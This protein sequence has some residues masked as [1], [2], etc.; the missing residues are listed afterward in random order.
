MRKLLVLLIVL[1]ISFSL[2]M[3]QYFDDFE[4]DEIG[5]SGQSSKYIIYVLFII[6]S[7]AVYYLFLSQ[8]PKLLSMGKNPLEAAASQC[9]KFSGIVFLLLIVMF[10]SL[11]GFEMSNAYNTLRDPWLIVFLILWVVYLIA[12]MSNKS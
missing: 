9:L 3:A 6:V 7:L 4:D 1:L 5:A 10:L 8:Y 11:N 2:L 12:A